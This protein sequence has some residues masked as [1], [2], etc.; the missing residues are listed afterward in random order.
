MQDIYSHKIKIKTYNDWTQ[1]T[2]D[3]LPQNSELCKGRDAN[4]YKFLTL[5]SIAYGLLFFAVQY[6]LLM[7]VVS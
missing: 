2:S 3:I 1:P 4:C 6:V 5:N 7:A